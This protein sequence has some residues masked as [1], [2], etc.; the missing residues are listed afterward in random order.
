[1]KI[2]CLLAPHLPVQVERRGDPGLDD[3]PLVVGGRP[4][5][6][7][8]VLDC[9]PTA[10]AAG[11]WPGMRLTQAEA[12]CPTAR[13]LPADEAAYQAAHR[14]LDQVPRQ[15]T[16]RVETA[17]LGFLFADGSGLG[18]SIGSDARL[19]RHVAREAERAS[20]LDVR[21]GLAGDR[22]TA[23]QAARAAP[24][25]GWCPVLPGQARAF[26]SP[27]PLSTLPAEPEVLRRLHL[28]GVRTLGA[29]AGLPRPAVVRQFG[30]QAGYLHDLAAGRDSRPLQPDAPPLVLEGGHA[31]EPPVASRGPLAAQAERI[32]DALAADLARRGYQ[33]QGL[34]LR[35]EDEMG[36]THTA[37][38]PV[39]PPSA[40]PGRLVRKADVLLERVDLVHPVVDVK[41]ILY[42][43]RPAHLGV[44]QL[45]LFTSPT[46]ARRRRLQEAICRLRERFGEMIIVVAS[47]LAPPPPR[48]IQ[49]TRDPQGQPRALVWSDHIR[50]VAQIYEHW[51]ER[52]RWWAR[53]RRR[54]YYRAE[55]DDGQMRVVFRDLESDRW[56]L[57][58][59]SI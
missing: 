29:L 47:L 50:P 5:D 21:V 41:V 11:V 52:R 59:R 25:A 16:N 37:S 51:R 23:E 44:T 35:L 15:F 10:A 42:P 49:V 14:T 32:V 26:L 55:T 56:W 24:A 6:P 36:N 33:A 17:G 54:D 39:E 13:F 18:R 9:C 58:R 43:L 1:M 7:G 57:E 12:L 3:R 45:A 28:L 19:V 22:F 4:W 53:P 20:G 27:L 40:D 2:I 38:A 8:A 46:D 48:P 30:P 31:F 34:R